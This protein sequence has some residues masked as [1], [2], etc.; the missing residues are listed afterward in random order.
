MISQE[1]QLS[2]SEIRAK[3]RDGA[4]TKEELRLALNLLR[5]DRERASTT[6]T[7]S[8]SASA[9]SKADANVN[10]DDLLDLLE[11]SVKD[12]EE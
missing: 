3:A 10:S 5:G 8:K 11:R 4:A 1:T 2:I 9:K 12:K 7:K 6:S